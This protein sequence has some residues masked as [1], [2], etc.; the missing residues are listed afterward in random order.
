MITLLNLF[1]VLVPLAYALVWADYALLF[2]RD[3]ATARKSVTPALVGAALIHLTGIFTRAFA[4]HR[5]PM[6]N[7]PEVLS[8]LG[9]SVVVV[10]L[11]LERRQQNKH[12]GVFVLGLVVPLGIVSSILPPPV[13]PA[14]ALLRSPLFGL[15]TLLALLG[16][17]AFAVCAIYGLMFLLLHRNL[18]RQT[19]GRI[20][21]NLPSLD[22][23]AGMTV[24]AALIGFCAL[25]LTMLVGMIWGSRAMQSALLPG[26]FW[27]DPKIFVTV[28]VW[29]AYGIGIGARF[30]LRWSNRPTVILFMA[31]F[32]V[33]V[34]GVVALN[35]FLHT[36]H[37]FTT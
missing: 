17:S 26:T 14:S 6:G 13:G 30:V 9:L 32:C 34:L 18:R 19:F 27:H 23:L 15:H 33:A 11:V 24:S 37:R 21:Q 29:A 5:C 4:V 7:L 3:D 8:L 20:F 10:Y 35:T 22:G 28:A 36:F 31:A 25:S 12:T 1:A 2:F 16:Y